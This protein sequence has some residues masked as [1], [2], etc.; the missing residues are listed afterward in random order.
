MAKEQAGMIS[1]RFTYITGLKRP[2]FRNARL[3]GSWNNWAEIPLQEII[4][5][6]GC[7]AFA[8]AVHFDD[9][10]AGQK[11]RWG[12]R[13]DG[14]A[15]A[16]AWAVNLEVPNA[17]SQDRYREFTLPTA[18]GSGEERYYFTYSRRLGAQKLYAS[19]SATP[20]LKCSV[21]APNANEV[22]VVF[23]RV[24]NGYI[25]DDGTGIDPA[26]PIMALQKGAAGIWES[27]PASDF[28]LIG[29]S[30]MADGAARLLREA[31]FGDD[32]PLTME[33]TLSGRVRHPD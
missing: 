32:R 4:A 13:L 28:S 33:P 22:D 27:V 24:D 17:E 9:A 8:A 15:G 18:G 19:G 10:L 14:P 2:V 31:G 1:V 11:H 3:A 7:P 29:D 12:V 21:W 6:D 16:N 23:G 25:A 26:R 5:E 20:D 30:D